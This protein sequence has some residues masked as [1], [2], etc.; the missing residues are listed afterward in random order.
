MTSRTSLDALITAT[1][2]AQYELQ[3]QVSLVHTLL[4][5]AN[6]APSA[7]QVQHTRKV[8]NEVSNICASADQKVASMKAMLK[9]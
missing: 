1:T 3:R 9:G 4:A 2:A 6:P 8:I 5:G 7:D